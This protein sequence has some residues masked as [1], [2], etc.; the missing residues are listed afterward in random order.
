MS[1][2]WILEVD[3]LDGVA[4]DPE[5]SDVLCESLQSSLKK[6]SYHWDRLYR[7]AAH[8]HI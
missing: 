7:L 2:N 5:P 8:I 6:P 4:A 3:G 1:G